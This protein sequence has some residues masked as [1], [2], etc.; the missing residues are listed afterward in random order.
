[1]KG[2]LINKNFTSFWLWDLFISLG[3]KFKELIIP[4]L[5]LTVTNSPFIT[6]M[7]SLSQLIASMVLVVPIGGWIENQNKLKVAAFFQ[8]LYGIGMFTLAFVLVTDS[9]NIGLMTTILVMMS[10]FSMISNT[11]FS[12]MVPNI[13]GRENLLKAHTG[14]EAAD[15]IA[16]I[17]GP[18]LGG[19]LLGNAGAA[20]GLIVCGILSLIATLFIS[21]ITYDEKQKNKKEVSSKD[22]TK[23][24][25][26]QS[27]DG[28]KYLTA[29]PQQKIS[30]VAL[31]ILQFSTVYIE[32]VV[33]FH[34]QMFLGLSEQAIGI[35]FSSAGV[36]A[37]L[38]LFIMRRFDQINWIKS[39]SFLL[40][41]SGAGVFIIFLSNNF[42]LMCL[43]M[44]L[45]DGGLSMAFIIQETVH[46]GISPDEFLARI[47]SAYYLVGALFSILGTILAGFF[48]EVFT[49]QMALF[50]GTIILLGTGFII[51]K[52]RNF[53]VETNKL[54]P[55]YLREK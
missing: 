8:F 18:L 52:F 15:S 11:A 19:Y 31:C 5:V 46:Q 17:I 42:Y 26:K 41:S 51:L 40:L 50:L 33:L 35:L 34:A 2:L 4:L 10:I 30:T 21:F 14:L 12:V 3:G 38:G 7:V 22:K 47:D 16:T 23:E 32:L 37:I 49:G 6:S 29:N 20:I 9:L 25:I 44:A 28:F 45:F 1:M 27:F 13:V 54:E 24:F 39:L 53:G 43:G 55:I 48:P 36:G